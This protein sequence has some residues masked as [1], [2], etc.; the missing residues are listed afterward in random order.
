[1]SDEYREDR[2]EFIKSMFRKFALG[3]LVLGTGGLVG[4]QKSGIATCVNNG[5]CG[6]CNVYRECELPQALS[7][8]EARPVRR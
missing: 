3:G 2:R 4:K 1:M 6:D 5:I 7:R 8:K